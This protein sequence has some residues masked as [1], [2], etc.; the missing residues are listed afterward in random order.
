[1]DFASLNASDIEHLKRIE[2]CLELCEQYLSA[3]TSIA[4]H[5]KETIRPNT[6][7]TIGKKNLRFQ[8]LMAMLMMNAASWNGQHVNWYT[9]HLDFSED[10]GKTP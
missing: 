7:M 6:S 5:I 3:C 4:V 1:L 10:V 8:V 9:V 2:L